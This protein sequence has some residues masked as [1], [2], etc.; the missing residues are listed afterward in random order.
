[1]SALGWPF[2]VVGGDALLAGSAML[3]IGGWPDAG[4]AVGWL[5][6]G[7]AVGAGRLGLTTSA[8]GL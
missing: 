3:G 6:S 2:L 8:A 1:M 5:A 7:G 4:G